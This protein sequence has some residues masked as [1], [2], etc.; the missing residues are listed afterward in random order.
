MM[1]EEVQQPRLKVIDILNSMGSDAPVVIGFSPRG[2]VNEPFEIKRWGQ[3]IVKFGSFKKC[4]YLATAVNGFFTNGGRRCYVLNLGEQPAETEA[5]VAAVMEGLKTLDSLENIPFILAPG[6]AE[7]EVHDAILAY[8]E[9]RGTYALLDGPE[10]LVETVVEAEDSEVADEGE[11]EV[12]EAVPVEEQPDVLAEDESEAREKYEN[13]PYVI[14]DFGTVVYPWIYLKDRVLGDFYIPPTG[15]I[16]GILAS[17]Y[18]SGERP[19]FSTVE[20][21]ILLKYKFTVDEKA[22]YSE[23]GLTILGYPNKKPGVV[24]E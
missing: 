7:A 10:D 5:V 2:P 17:L 3:F 16:A 23:R 8:C 1:T 12:E 21:T 22:E 4:G 19:R 13:L 14:G 6:E 20:G 11:A 9:V 18:N 15:H 24:F